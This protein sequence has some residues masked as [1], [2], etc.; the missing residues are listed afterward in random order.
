M[1]SHCS[2]D[3]EVVRVAW[4]PAD[5][6]RLAQ[7]QCAYL[8][9]CDPDGLRV[10]SN[11]SLDGCVEYF[12]CLSA[13]APLLFG[14]VPTSVSALEICIESLGSRACA[15]EATPY[16]AQ[17]FSYSG[18]FP[19]G[20]ACGAPDATALTAP[21]ADAPGSSEACIRGP[22]E[23]AP[24]QTGSYCAVTDEDPRFGLYY[25]GI[26]ED[27]LKL[28]AACG[29]RSSCE[30]GTRCVLERCA[31]PLEQDAPCVD[32]I[33]CRTYNCEAGRCA[34]S[35]S[36]QEPFLDVVGRACTSRW[37]CGWQAG[38][39]CD[40][41]QCQPLHETGEP[42]SDEDSGPSCR[43]G[44]YCFDNRCVALGC[45]L[46]VG[47][48]CAEFR[49]HCTD[50]YCRAGIC[51]ATALEAGDPCD[52]FCHKG[53]TCENHVCVPISR[54]PLGGACDFDRDCASGFCSRDLSAECNWTRCSVPACDGCGTCAPPPTARD[55]Q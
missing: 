7:A 48:P 27:R 18:F 32:D 19:W 37:D 21:P 34:R 45:S 12:A 43:A 23:I 22:N 33:Q 8:E 6:L 30:S 5:G 44:N 38:L 39:T 9:R 55:C 16:L 26:C 47:E 29:V 20:T 50:G 24:C 40:E 4:S 35:T 52:F 28:G 36:A 31:V 41:G 15:D 54:E 49:N 11:D 14:K 46:D 3:S 25:C 53:L 42:C 10:F 13:E 1:A 2:P 17:S 51:A